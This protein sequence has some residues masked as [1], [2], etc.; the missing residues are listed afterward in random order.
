MN[1]WNYEVHTVSEKP[2]FKDFSDKVLEC[3]KKLGASFIDIYIYP[4]TSGYKVEIYPLLPRNEYNAIAEC[5]YKST[6]LKTVTVE[7]STSLYIIAK[8]GN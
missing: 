5:I 3:L 6:G 7:K 4:I 8:K 2:E 1:C